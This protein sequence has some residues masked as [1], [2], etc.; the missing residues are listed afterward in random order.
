MKKVHSWFKRRKVFFLPVNTGYVEYGRPD[1]R[2]QKFYTDRCQT[3]LYCAIV[4]NV[5]IPGGVPSNNR[6]AE[7]SDANAWRELARGM[8]DNGVVPGVQL[9]TAWPGYKGIK[10]FV[11]EPNCDALHQYRE[12]SES[13]SSSDI[14]RIFTAL[15]RGSKLAYQAGFRHLQIHA[16]HG[17]LFSILIDRRLSS[18][19]DLTLRLV[20]E[21]A[22]EVASWGVESSLRFSVW[23]GIASIDDL[24]QMQW[25]SLIASLPV[26]YFD[27]SAGFYN[28]DKRLI[29][30]TLRRFL[31]SRRN[32]TLELAARNPQAQF[33]ISGK[34]S[35]LI[36]QSVPSNIHIGICRD[37]IA[38]PKFLNEINNGCNDCMKC[39][40]FSR[41][42]T[43]LECGRW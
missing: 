3:G 41:G 27:V 26:N 22:L 37:L 12:I 16:A 2:C 30:P 36:G 13:M 19:S 35:E 18:H 9:T 24:H 25:E 32:V 6:C 1:E 20:R 34:A 31:L 21:W 29:Y 33:I 39:H 11:A 40:Y 8:S 15:H 23:I 42:R 17:Y 28:I 43:H 10:K 7:I 5:V 4:G 14:R 38:N